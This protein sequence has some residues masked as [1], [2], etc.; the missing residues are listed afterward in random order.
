MRPDSVVG[1]GG[2]GQALEELLAGTR[3]RGYKQIAMNKENRERKKETLNLY[4]VLG[5]NPFPSKV[6]KQ[7]KQQR[8]RRPQSLTESL[9]AQSSLQLIE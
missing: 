1:E 6:E 4:L 5:G 7:H 8:K 9:G 3:E 2:E